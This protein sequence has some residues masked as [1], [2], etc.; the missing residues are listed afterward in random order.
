MQELSSAELERLVVFKG[1]GT[2]DADYWFVGWEEHISRDKDPIEE[3]RI[4]A[5]W[6][7]VADLGEA[8]RSLGTHLNHYVPTWAV[9]IR[10]LLRLKEAPDWT[11]GRVV[12]GYQVNRLGRHGGESFLAEV[13][14]LPSPCT[15]DWPYP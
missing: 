15:A 3:L 12:R 1:Y 8:N 7:D 5:T 13:L 6:P 11:D 2:P 4:R 10:F 14:P 9:M